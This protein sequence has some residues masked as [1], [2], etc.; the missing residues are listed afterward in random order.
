MD[1]MDT[2]LG[3]DSLVKRTADMVEMTMNSSK[4]TIYLH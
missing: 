4:Y 3:I 1:Q 2:S